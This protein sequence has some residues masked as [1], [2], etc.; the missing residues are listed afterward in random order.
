MSKIYKQVDPKWMVKTL[1]AW[2]AKNKRDLPWRVKDVQNNRPDP[3][4]IWVSEIMLQQTRVEAVKG[5][6]DRFLCAFPNVESLSKA[7][8]DM[9]LK[10]WEGLGYYNRVRNMQFAAKQIMTD[11]VGDFPDSYDAILKLKGIGE[12]TAGAIASIAFGEAICAV[13]GNVL[14]VISRLYGRTEDIALA[15]TKKEMQQLLNEIVP[16]SHPGQFNQALMDLG[17]TVCVPNGAPKCEQCPWQERCVAHREDLTDVIPVKS[18]KAK[19]KIE[20]KTV[21]LLI[22]QNRVAIVKRPETGLLAGLWQFPMVDKADAADV[23]KKM[24]QSVVI[25]EGPVAK[26]IFTHKEWHMNS[27]IVQLPD[28]C[29]DKSKSENI[30]AEDI[31]FE[32]LFG[33]EKI[34]WTT[35]QEL[36][37][38]YSVPSA[39]QAYKQWLQEHI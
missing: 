19:R 1:E 37:N 27:F 7:P 35:R 9:L 31:C 28:N 12:Y 3:Y 11:Y 8:E 17:A 18:K 5:Y 38:T 33:K 13:D 23:I 26:H 10:M 36:E 6:Y 16:F 2:F 34:I 24:R 20:E 32:A 22:C 39:F 21:F 25:Q 15:S 29:L 14:R 4:H 30:G